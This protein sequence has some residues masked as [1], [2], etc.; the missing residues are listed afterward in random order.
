M[1]LSL[2]A[3]PLA[4][5]LLAGSPAF[6]AASN[7]TSHAS[8][9]SIP[10]ANHGGVDDWRAVGDS[11]IYFEDLHRHWYRAELMGPAF[12]LPFVEHIGIDAS[13]IGTLDKFGAIYVHG[14]RYDFR[15]FEQVAGPPQ[16]VLGAKHAAHKS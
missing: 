16:K 4:A 2:F 1:K 3:L 5:A 15:S 9:A 14:Q 6:A 10:F 7:S 8:E 13:P 11:T 12:D